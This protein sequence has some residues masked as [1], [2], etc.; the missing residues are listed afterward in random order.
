MILPIVYGLLCS[1]III[2][3]THSNHNLTVI[4]IGRRCLFVFSNITKIIAF[5][6]CVWAL[7]YVYI[8][9]IYLGVDRN[10]YQA[11]KIQIQNCKRSDGVAGLSVPSR[12]PPT[13]T[14]DQPLLG[15]QKHQGC[16]GGL[17]L[18]LRMPAS[19]SVFQSVCRVVTSVVRKSFVAQ[20][21]NAVRQSA[22]LQIMFH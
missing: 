3:W 10:V 18:T 20:S 14:P 8:H 5:K 21:C 12:T 17:R 19:S 15:K 11:A 1:S 9:F 4:G 13:P 6:L 16:P 7:A 22:H 2:S